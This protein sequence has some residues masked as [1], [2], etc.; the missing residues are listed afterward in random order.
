MTKKITTIVM[1]AVL[2]ALLLPSYITGGVTPAVQAQETED[3]RIDAAGASFAFPL[4]DLWRVK[5]AEINP[6]IKLNYQSIVSEE[7]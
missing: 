2:S 7:V 4:M 6:H 1:I 3:V 5:Y